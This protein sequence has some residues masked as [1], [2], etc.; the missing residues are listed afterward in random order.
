MA[1][2]THLTDFKKF[3]YK[4]LKLLRTDV[5]IIKIQKQSNALNFNHDRRQTMRFI[6]VNI[7]KYNTR[8]PPFCTNF[9][10][11]VTSVDIWHEAEQRSLG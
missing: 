3:L 11:A 8:T 7:C 4:S 1:C 2:Y 6:L 9:G 5:F 10:F